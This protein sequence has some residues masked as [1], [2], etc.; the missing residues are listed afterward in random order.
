MVFAKRLSMFTLLICC[1]ACKK[2][3]TIQVK[4]SDVRYVIEGV[5]TNEMRPW[6]VTLSRSRPFYADNDFEKISGAQVAIIDNGVI[7]TLAENEPGI[8]RT[9]PQ[10][11]IPGHTY[12]LSVRLGDQ[13][14]TATS[15]M[16][17]PV[18]ID[19]L[20]ITP[21]PFGQFQF[22]TLRYTDPPG[23]GNSYRFIQ[24][25]NAIKDPKIFWQNDEFTD[26]QQ[27]VTQLDTGVDK[28]DDPRAIQRGD[29][30]TIELLGIDKKIYQYWYSLRTGGGDGS[31]S[32]AAP[33]N[34]VTNIEGSALGYFSAH[35]LARKT[36]IAP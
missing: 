29:E 7:H 12:A 25:V 36:V 23:L 6:Q 35:T 26:G 28:K 22:A 15:I 19:S 21:G 5:V 9:A 32:T 31:G 14:F 30:V 2:V 17:P 27:V 13:Q 18:I 3:I 16:P 34:P 20:Y 8:Y 11:G 1:Q 4:E 24:Y 10:A 33:A